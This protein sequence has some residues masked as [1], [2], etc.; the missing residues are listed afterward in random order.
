MFLFGINGLLARV[1]PAFY[2]K[3]IMSDFADGNFHMHFLDLTFWA[4]VWLM[5]WDQPLIVIPS[6]KCWDAFPLRGI[7]ERAQNGSVLHYAN[8]CCASI[9]WNYFLCDF[10]LVIPWPSDT[11]QKE[12][13]HSSSSDIHSMCPW[14]I[15]IPDPLSKDSLICKIWRLNLPSDVTSVT[16]LVHR[17]E[18]G[19]FAL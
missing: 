12:L 8:P 10:R 3:L 19:Y 5:S 11:L 18:I 15:L 1:F 2:W 7:P 16:I 9:G 13:R 6:L 14:K 17:V 4:R